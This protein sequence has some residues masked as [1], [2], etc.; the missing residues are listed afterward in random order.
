MA[1][2]PQ[3]SPAQETPRKR[4]AV[5]GAYLYLHIG[6]PKT[7][8]TSLQGWLHANE[9]TLN[10][11]NL[12]YPQFPARYNDHTQ[13]K[14]QGLVT[15][16]IKGRLGRLRSLLNDHRDVIMSS[17]GLTNHLYD[18]PSSS[19][20]RF[21]HLTQERTVVAILVTRPPEAF[22]R[23]IYN[24]RVL[25]G[26][27]ERFGYATAQ[28]FEE[29]RTDAVLNRLMDYQKV[30]KDAK[31]AF[32]A[33]R[34]VTVELIRDW[35]KHVLR[36]IGL[37]EEDIPAE[38]PRLNASPNA[39]VIERVRQINSLQLSNDDRRTALSIVVNRFGGD[40]SAL[41]AKRHT[42]STDVETRIVGRLRSE[43]GWNI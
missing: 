36:A 30:I 32:G 42:P 10:R 22:A 40:S 20:E 14:Q 27:N 37:K 8:T 29:F 3:T 41:L 2:R 11:N 5:P 16:L 35:H 1:I 4:A 13:A 21:R 25:T 34:L 17:E 19:L 6:L 38:I 9:R 12:T 23:S 7:G 33:D 24:Q 26:P 15:G 43:L 28:T 39:D 18:F 31:A